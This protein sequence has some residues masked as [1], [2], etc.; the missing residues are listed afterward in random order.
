MPP[1]SGT[2]DLRALAR[3]ILDQ[4]DLEQSAGCAPRYELRPVHRRFV[5]GMRVGLLLGVGLGFASTGAG[6]GTALRE[7]FWLAYFALF[8]VGGTVSGAS[9]GAAAGLG[10]RWSQRRDLDAELASLVGSSSG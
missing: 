1:G 2:S 10:V 8:T 9:I 4:E 7:P 6:N 5:E 3:V